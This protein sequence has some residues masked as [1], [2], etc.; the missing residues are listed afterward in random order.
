MRVH[1]CS[2]GDPTRTLNEFASQGVKHTILSF[3]KPRG[4][5]Q[6]N[7]FSHWSAVVVGEIHLPFEFLVQ[8]SAA[9]GILCQCLYCTPAVSRLGTNET[10]TSEMQQQLPAGQAEVTRVSDTIQEEGEDGQPVNA[11]AET[12]EEASFK[13]PGQ[14]EFS[15]VRNLC[16]NCFAYLRSRNCLW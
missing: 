16:V 4:S 10:A 13:Q 6:K 15:S 14:S 7:G 1:T 2:R 5:W 3:V 9:W 11:A 12:K 8:P